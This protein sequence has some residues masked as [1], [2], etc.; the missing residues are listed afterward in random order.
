MMASHWIVTFILAVWSVRMLA[1]AANLFSIPRDES[2][3]STTMIFDAG[4]I[5]IGGLRPLLKSDYDK[6][7]A[8]LLTNNTYCGDPACQLPKHEKHS[9]AYLPSG[10]AD[11][12]YTNGE[13][14]GCGA[15]LR[16]NGTAY[17]VV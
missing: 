17:C 2:I 11:V 10:V 1:Q 5:L 14:A 8:I 6:L 16:C 7:V 3:I 9:V 15:G 12:C 13:E 4:T